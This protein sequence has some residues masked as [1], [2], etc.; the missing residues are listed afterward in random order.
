MEV[1]DALLRDKR[2][3]N[4]QLYSEIKLQTI[5]KTLLVRKNED[6]IR[7]KFSKKNTQNEILF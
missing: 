5:E 2:S 3:D 7:T 6:F 1:S 4:S